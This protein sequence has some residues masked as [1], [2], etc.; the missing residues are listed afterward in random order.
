[1]ITEENF[2]NNK[3]ASIQLIEFIA[4]LNTYDVIKEPLHLIFF[5]WCQDQ[6]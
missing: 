4:R 2:H 5:I 1:M 6:F 3:Q